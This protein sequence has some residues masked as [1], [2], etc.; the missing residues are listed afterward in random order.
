MTLYDNYNPKISLIHDDGREEI[1]FESANGELIY[2]SNSYGI[3]KRTKDGFTYDT[4]FSEHQ[5]FDRGGFLIKT[6]KNGLVHN[7]QHVSK[8][9][10]VVSDDFGQSMTIMDNGYGNVDYI[11]TPGGKTYNYKYD[12]QQR[13]IEISKSGKTR[14][15]H[16]DDIRFPFALTGITD[17]NGSRYVTWIYDN[18][19]R[20]IS[21][22]YAGGMNK[23][24]VSR[25]NYVT[26]V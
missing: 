2:K 8:L 21:S 25:G 26:G 10:T 7:I 23:Y 13:L 12:V 17:E 6:T 19:E 20:A 24:T 18:A 14:K 1:Y 16:Y 5:E 9:E 22:E 11:K 3:L 15:Y 4:P